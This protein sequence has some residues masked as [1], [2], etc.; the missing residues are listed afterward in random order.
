MP[1][2]SV[3]I[4]V[5]NVQ[6]YLAECLDSVLAQD[7]QDWEAICVND[8]STDNC[9]TILS[10][11]A[12]K[13][14]RF[15][16][17]SQFNQGLSAAR[18]AAL[19]IAIGDWV[20]FLDSDD[21]LAPNA[22]SRLY[23]VAQESNQPVI[24]STSFGII[25]QNNLTRNTSYQVCQPALELLLKNPKG[26]SSACGK[27]Y[28][29]DILKEHRFI[30]GIYFEDWPFIVTLFANISGFANIDDKLYLYRQTNGSIVRSAFS[31]HKID[32]YIKGMEFVNEQL[33]NTP[34][35]AL[36]QKR[37]SIAMR[38]CINKTW[39][40]KEHRK[41]LAPYLVTQVKMAHEKGY[42]SWKYI[43]L[44][45]IIRYLIMKYF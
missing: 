8:G 21:M 11:Y 24:V 32:S 6:N 19:D 43:S 39:R 17:I 4:P 44:K 30:P 34:L 41:S 22:L 3:L 37:C 14:A 35:L 5:Y 45:T 12:N 10:D 18:N 42:F 7:F 20:I 9:A 29:S 38:M 33:A 2:I 13:D 16:V 15:K 36:A 26:Y 1:K 40:D 31:I 28:R 27:L 23:H 25:G